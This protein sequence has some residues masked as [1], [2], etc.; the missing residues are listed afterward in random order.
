[1]DAD[2]IDTAYKLSHDYERRIKFQA[3]VQDFV[4]QSISSTINLTPWGSKDNNA[5]KVT[6]F[7]T[8]LAK[9]A[10]RLRGFTAYPDGSRGG[11]PLSEC[12]FAEA[13]ANKGV[14]FSETDICEYTG[15][16]GSCGV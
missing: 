1:L 7:A 8:T 14:V 12:S 10:P 13:M 5:D 6:E 9:Y 15:K 2:S 16:G 3:D 4:D 11:Q